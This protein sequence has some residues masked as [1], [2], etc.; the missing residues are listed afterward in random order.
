MISGVILNHFW[1]LVKLFFCAESISY[2]DSL[3]NKVADWGKGL[4]VKTRWT[5][6]P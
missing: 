1:N 2:G 3:R 5:H 4:S 6:N